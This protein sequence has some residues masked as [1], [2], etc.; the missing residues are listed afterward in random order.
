MEFKKDNNDNQRYS[1]FTKYNYTTQI[2]NASNQDW[3]AVLN[4]L[5]H[6]GECDQRRRQLTT[7]Y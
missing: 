6:T 4:G 3:R 5:S 1:T 2:C 7:S